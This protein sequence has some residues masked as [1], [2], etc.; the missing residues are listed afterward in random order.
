M[1][2][3]HCHWHIFRQT[4]KP[5]MKVLSRVWFLKSTFCLLLSIYLMSWKITCIQIAAVGVQLFHC[6]DEKWFTIARFKWGAA[7]RAKLTS[8]LRTPS[9]HLYQRSFKNDLLSFTKYVVRAELVWWYSG[10]KIYKVPNKTF[11]Y[12]S[13][14]KIRHHQNYYWRSFCCPC[15]R[16]VKMEKKKHINLPLVLLL[17][18]KI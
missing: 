18:F 8:L 14:V 16:K 13:R 4:R 7:I 17:D 11:S 2:K 6:G 3:N 10:S 5:L 15:R 9:C 1:F 12:F